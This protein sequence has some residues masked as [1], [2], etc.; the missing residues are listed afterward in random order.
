MMLDLGHRGPPD[1]P[2]SPHIQAVIENSEGARLIIIDPLSR[3]H[4]LEENSN[5]QMSVLLGNLDHVSTRT[6]AAVLFVHHV[7]KLAVR[8]GAGDSQAASRG[9]SALAEHVKWSANLA[10]MTEDE[11]AR[12]KIDPD[13]RG[14]Y[15]SLRVTKQSYGEPRP[16]RWFEWHEDGVLLPADLAFIASPA[17]TQRKSPQKKDRNNV[18]RF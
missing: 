18:I 16:P 9:A 15:L 10:K 4:N 17:T 2:I 6:G 5:N 12:H 7:N 8:E 11:A 14:H 13:R 1:D 3:F